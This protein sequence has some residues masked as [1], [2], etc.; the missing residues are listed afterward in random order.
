MALQQDGA[1]FRKSTEFIDKATGSVAVA[2]V[3]DP[4]SLESSEPVSL[5]LHSWRLAAVIGSLCLGIFLLALDMNIIAVAIPRITSDFHSLDDVAWY[6]SAYLLTVTA[7]QPLF[8]N[9][10]KYFDPKIVYM[11]SIALFEC[12]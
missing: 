7:F 5:F 10:Y 8:G 2:D 11:G 9:L 6:G 4:T 1:P 12:K 3:S